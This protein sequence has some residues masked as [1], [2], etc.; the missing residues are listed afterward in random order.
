M[1]ATALLQHQVKETMVEEVIINLEVVEG[2][3]LA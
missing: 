3:H 2:G 1:A